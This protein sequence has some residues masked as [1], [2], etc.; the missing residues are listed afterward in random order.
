MEPG[1]FPLTPLLPPQI[2]LENV[3]WGN[4]NRFRLHLASSF[5]WKGAN[6]KIV[7]SSNFV[8]MP[9]CLGRK[10]HAKNVTCHFEIWYF[11]LWIGS[12]LFQ[13]MQKYVN[14]FF[15][16]CFCLSPR[17]DFNW[18]KLFSFFFFSSY[19]TK[20]SI[21]CTVLENML[22][23]QFRADR[24]TDFMSFPMRSLSFRVC[25]LQVELA[26]SV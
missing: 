12:Y 26:A 10:F 11:H 19:W 9:A 5:G 22:R 15:F 17:S 3:I 13:V 20:E 16:S 1:N 21:I 24:R 8:K 18:A 6:L 25:D 4:N 23:S 2:S 7:Y 14:I